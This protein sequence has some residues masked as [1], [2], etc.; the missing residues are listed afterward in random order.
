METFEKEV[1]EKLGNLFYAIAKDQ[2]VKPLE[3][4]ELKMII[5]KHG[6]SDAGG[7][8]AEVV[9]EAAHHIVLAM[10]ALKAEEAS[11][12][13]A[14]Q[15][16]TKFYTTHKKQFSDSLKK[17]ILLTAEAITEVF[18]SQ[19]HL[20]NNHIIKLKLLFQNSGLIV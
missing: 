15:E 1:F 6:V 5:R 14:F 8:A 9:P 19:S 2:H 11:A 4:G 7:P 16:F 17:K 10:D 3:F 18:P 12:E 20:K 13:E